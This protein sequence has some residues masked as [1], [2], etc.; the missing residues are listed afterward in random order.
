M[1]TAT[2]T[3]PRF[4][5]F[6][7]E[8]DLI[9]TAGIAAIDPRTLE[10][11]FDDFDAQAR[12]VL[13]RLDAVVAE[14]A[15]PGARLLRVE[16]YLVDR[17][18]FA[19]WNAAFAAHFGEAAPARTTLICA[20][21][22]AG[23]LIEVQAL[24]TAAPDRVAPLR[25]APPPA[26]A[27]P[28]L[29]IGDLVE[30]YTATQTLLA[31]DDLGWWRRLDV[32][33]ADGAAPPTIS[34]TGPVQRAIAGALERLGWLASGDGGLVLTDAGR[35]VVRARGFVRVVARGW[36][37][38]FA[39]AGTAATNAPLPAITDPDAVARGCTEIARRAPGTFRAIADRLRIAPGT[40]IDLGCADAGRLIGLAAMAPHERLLGVDLAE[41]VIV[42]AT[43]RLRADP[44]HPAGHVRLMSGDVSPGGPPPAWL[45][46]VPRD[47]VTTA[48]SFFLLHQLAS[49]GGGIAAV[50]D[51][52]QRWFPNLRRFVIGDGIRTPGARWADQPWFSPTYELYHELTGVRLWWEREYCEAF[53]QQ[54]W[55]I[56]DRREVEHPMLVMWT[57][58]RD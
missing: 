49:D 36:E 28:G 29:E 44:D 3:P 14:A 16:C 54:G 15:G 20:P 57:L 52:W 33:P 18:H 51:G 2:V 38:T 10:P 13:E 27:D 23:L 9:A 34:P 41:D 47:E 6:S 21:P 30:G 12:W 46:G 37:P 1:S 7:R 31:A 24:A 39:A 58:E 35:A 53:E 22:V 48:M 4:A 17:R 19:R 32:E 56:V 43:A 50:L 55:R 45:Q 25:L 8:G 42:D 40:T 26:P 11:L 5:P